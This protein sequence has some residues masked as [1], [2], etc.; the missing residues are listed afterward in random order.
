MGSII[1][2]P[3]YVINNPPINTAKLTPAS[4]AMCKNAD[5]ELSSLLLMNKSAVNVLMTTPTPATQLTV[6]PIVGSGWENRT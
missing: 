5:R 3:V 6:L 2:M 4:A 1:S